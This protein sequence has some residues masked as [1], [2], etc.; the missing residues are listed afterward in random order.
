MNLS[1]EQTSGFVPTRTVCYANL[2][3]LYVSDL[4]ET[5]RRLISFVFQATGFFFQS[6]RLIFAHKAVSTVYSFLTTRPLRLVAGIQDDKHVNYEAQ[7]KYDP[8][9][10]GAPMEVVHYIVQVGS[11]LHGEL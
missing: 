6:R 8:P 9:K 4:H 1:K 10:A 7:P 2:F 5:S 11:V 3:F